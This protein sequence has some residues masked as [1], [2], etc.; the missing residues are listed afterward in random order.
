MYFVILFNDGR[1]QIVT[2]IFILFGAIRSV[3]ALEIIDF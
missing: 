2:V 3:F 1:R